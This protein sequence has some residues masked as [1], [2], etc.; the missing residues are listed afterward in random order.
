MSKRVGDWGKEKKG[1]GLERESL[2]FRAFLPPPPLFAP[3]TLAKKVCMHLLRGNFSMTSLY[4]QPKS[5]LQTT[6]ATFIFFKSVV[7]ILPV[8][9][10]KEKLNVG[11]LPSPS[12]AGLCQWIV[13][14]YCNL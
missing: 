8:T 10:V 14:C 6:K 11:T 4:V 5:L 13:V 12:M 3:A 1:G 2:P 9:P 7:L